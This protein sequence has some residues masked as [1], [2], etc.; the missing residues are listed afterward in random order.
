MASPESAGRW[1][2]VKQLFDQAASLDRAARDAFFDSVCAND[3][4]LRSEV[5]QLLEQHDRGSGPIQT[6]MGPTAPTE[7]T[8][9]QPPAVVAGQFEIVKRLGGGGMGEVYEARD[10]QLGEHVA[11][12]MVRAELVFNPRVRDRFKHEILNGRRVTHPN[13]CR[14]YDLVRD[15]SP[16]AGP[17]AFTMELLTGETLADLLKREGPLSTERALPLVSQMAAGLTALHA[18][19]IVHRDFKPSNVMLVGGNGEMPLVKITDFGL[20]RRDVGVEDDG[21]AP[22]S[23]SRDIV[24]TPIY[25]APEQLTAER[26]KFGPATDVYAFGLVLYEIVTGHRPFPSESYAGNLLDKTTGRPNP[27]R[28]HAPE[29][30]EAWDNTIQCCLEKE[31]ADRPQSPQAVLDALEGRTEAPTPPEPAPPWYSWANRR[32]RW[33]ALALLLVILLSLLTQFD[34][35]FQ[36]EGPEQLHV[37]V[38]PF[39]VIG[40]DTELPAFADGLMATITRRLTQFEGANENLVVMAPSTVLSRGVADPDAAAEK[41]G[42]NYAVE[43]DLQAS[44]D[45][46]VLT[47]T[48]VDANEG[49]QLDTEVVTGSRDNALALQDGAVRRLANALNLRIQPE[50]LEAAEGV[51]EMTLGAAQFYTAGVGY[52]QRSYVTGNIENAITQFRRAIELDDEYA[53]AYAGLC[54]AQWRLHERTSDPRPLIEAESDCEK[55]LGLNDQL[56]EAHVA[57]GHV[58][59]STGKYEGAIR[60]FNAALDLERKHA[61]ALLG[62]AQVFGE[63]G[64]TEQAL[65]AY[66][67]AI[68]L[69]AADWRMHHRLGLFHHGQRDYEAAIG[70]FQRVVDL[71][72]RSAQALLNLGAAFHGAGRLDRAR[73][74]YEQAMDIEPRPY[75]LSNLAKL[76]R[77]EGQFV[78]AKDALEQA[79]NLKEHDFELW[80]HL[81]SAYEYVNDPRVPETYLKA[82]SLIEEALRINPERE[83]LYSLLAHCYAGADEDVQA[84]EWLVKASARRLVANGKEMLRNA[85]TFARLGD[86]DAAFDWLRA[87]GERGL[88]PGEIEE[89]LRTRKWLRSLREDPRSR[90]FIESPASVSPEPPFERQPR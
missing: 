80:Q 64:R 12:K 6:Q 49:H 63:M 50:Y 43:G 23:G 83:E 29:L 48:I 20:A 71:T 82:A 89:E 24:G 86:L 70:P 44:G 90:Q 16:E 28:K 85:K 72:P 88:P 11:L 81:A 57:F 61:E 79:V 2:R 47:L 58:Q 22:P 76:Y 55:A 25:M 52:L 13:I 78:K 35:L 1:Q 38:L 19:S 37:A 14:I 69:R 41:L 5:E 42:V 51:N 27:P 7:P 67:Q 46:L 26:E 21:A 33:G 10:R 65:A 15:Q 18:C 73:A 53:P 32:L 4:S 34:R 74:L 84:R 3:P 8:L 56:P 75:A 60:S 40:N 66:D 68:G 39:T 59:L 77:G 9:A 45:R 31:P 36:V 62:L 87:A 30:P 54:E 17:L